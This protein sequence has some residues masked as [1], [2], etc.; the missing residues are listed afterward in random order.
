MQDPII[1]I[2]NEAPEASVIICSVNPD[3][4]R[5]C[6]ESIKQT[7]GVRA[8]FVIIDNRIENMPIAKAYNLA[9]SRAESP[10]LLFLHEDLVF[11]NEGW[12]RSLVGKLKENATG[13]VGFIGTDFR[14][15]CYSGWNCGGSDYIGHITYINKGRRLS[16]HNEPWTEGKKR[17]DMFYPALLCDGLGICVSRRVWEEI[18]FDE[19]A[20]TGFHCYDIDYCLSVARRYRNYIY[21]GADVCHFSNGS[22]NDAWAEATLRLSD[23][24]WSQWLPMAVPGCMP[25][26]VA[27]KGAMASYNFAF[28]LI[29]DV[30]IS[31]EVAAKVYRAY[32]QRARYQPELRRYLKTLRW[33]WLI[34]RVWGLSSLRQR[35]I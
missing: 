12:G 33:Q 9:A 17:G 10:A 2:K 7:I 20:L 23:T 26:D 24:K 14:P 4:R 18:P 34:K 15:D 1:H 8:E 28:T 3:L 30:N 16:F 5:E 19:V 31:R 22:L 32:K 13:A 29:R 21:M 27:Q 6:I 25:E 35:E 11:Y